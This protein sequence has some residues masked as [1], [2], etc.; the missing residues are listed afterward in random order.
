MAG[1]NSVI[2]ILILCVYFYG[3]F[4]VKKEKILCCLLLISMHA[5]MLKMLNQR[6]SGLNLNVL[7][8]LTRNM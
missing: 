6:Y 4:V 5:C 1:R 8:N 7:V 2:N 3:N